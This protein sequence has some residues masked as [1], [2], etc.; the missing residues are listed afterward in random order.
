MSFVLFS[1]GKEG[2]EGGLADKE[3]DIRMKI[4]NKKTMT[5]ADFELYI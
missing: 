5:N 3:V 1:T 2:R 4:I